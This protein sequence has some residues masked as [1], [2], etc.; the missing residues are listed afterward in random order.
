MICF[1]SIEYS[2]GCRLYGFKRD[3]SAA[4]MHCLAY[5]DGAISVGMDTLGRTL[6]VLRFVFWDECLA[7]SLEVASKPV[8]D[9]ALLDIEDRA[10]ETSSIS[11]TMDEAIEPRALSGLRVLPSCTNLERRSGLQR[12]KL[13][14]ELTQIHDINHIKCFQSQKRHNV[15]HTDRHQLTC[16][17]H[18]LLLHETRLS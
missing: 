2:S 14:Y 13:I 7:V 12:K 5:S 15:I 16:A 4:A 1:R 11:V 6:Y 18:E 3:D 9:V 10:D 17:F 8:G